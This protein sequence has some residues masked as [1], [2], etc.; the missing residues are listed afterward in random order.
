MAAQT[1]AGQAPAAAAFISRNLPCLDLYIFVQ[2]PRPSN[3]ANAPLVAGAPRHSITPLC[4]SCLGRSDCA[5]RASVPS[6]PRRSTGFTSTPTD[7][8][9]WLTPL[10]S[11]GPGVHDDADDDVDCCLGLSGP[12]RRSASPT[13]GYLERP[14]WPS[15]PGSSDSSCADTSCGSMY[16]AALIIG[17][18][19]CF[20]ICNTS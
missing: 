9:D 16:R 15:S 2:L 18:R 14:H 1:R 5:P 8:D 11:D 20:A 17:N 12:R 4:L 13:V 3:V 10:P 19:C 7:P 6:V